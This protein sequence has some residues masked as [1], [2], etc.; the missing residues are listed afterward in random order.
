MNCGSVSFL[1]IEDLTK[2]NRKKIMVGKEVF[3]EIITSLILFGYNMHKSIKKSTGAQVKKGNG[4]G[5]LRLQIYMEP[6]LELEPDP[7]LR[8]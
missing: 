4:Q 8:S 3:L 2:S 1:F 7:Q 6:E 5:I